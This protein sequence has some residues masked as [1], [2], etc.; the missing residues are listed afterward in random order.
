MKGMG[1]LMRHKMR[2]GFVIGLLI[3]LS[4]CVGQSVLKRGEKDKNLILE[5]PSLHTVPD[6]PTKTSTEERTRM[7]QEM[8]KTHTTDQ[9]LNEK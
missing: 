2:L 9:K 5:T 1:T 8:K 6:R 7:A 4:G 3:T